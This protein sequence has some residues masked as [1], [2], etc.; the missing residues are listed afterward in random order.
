MSCEEA[1]HQHRAEEEHV[2]SARSRCR[3][4]Q[5]PESEGRS[6]RAHG[7]RVTHDGVPEQVARKKAPRARRAHSD[8]PSTFRAR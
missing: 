4:K 7:E 3:L 2:R 8:Q 1:G 5:L 6:H